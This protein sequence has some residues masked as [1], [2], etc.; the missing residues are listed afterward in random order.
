MAVELA[1]RHGGMD[2]RGW[3]KTTYDL[4]VSDLQEQYPDEDWSL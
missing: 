3:A 1:E 2:A 4:I